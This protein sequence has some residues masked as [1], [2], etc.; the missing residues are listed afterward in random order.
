MR[1]Y[2]ENE[3]Y[4]N[5]ADI[6]VP[7]TNVSVE[8]PDNLQV[9]EYEDCWKIR[10]VGNNFC[11]PVMIEYQNEKQ[12][13]QEPYYVWIDVAGEYRELRYSYPGDIDTMLPDSEMCIPVE[14]I[15]RYTNEY[16]NQEE[17]VSLSDYELRIT[18]YDENGNPCYDR[19]LVNV[20]MNE[21]ENGRFLRLTSGGREGSTDI[22]IRAFAKDGEGQEYELCDNWIHV[23][24]S[25]SYWIMEP[26]CLEA[27]N[28]ERYNPGVGEILDLGSFDLYVDHYETGMGASRDEDVRIRLRDYDT[29]AWEVVSGTEGDLP[30]LKRT[31]N[32]G[33]EIVLIAE[34]NMAEEGLE[35]WKQVAER[36]Y[37]FD[38]LNYDIRFDDLRGGDYTW[39][40]ENEDIDLRMNTENLEGTDYTVEW[41]TGVWDENGNFTP[42]DP[43]LGFYEMS[44]DGTYITLHGAVLGT[45]REQMRDGCWFDVEA[46]IMMGG[47][48]MSR[49]GTGICVNE[50]E[51][52][53][54]TILEHPIDITEKV[55]SNALFE[56][57]AEG[58]DL[59]YQ[60]QYRASEAGT[61]A[62]TGLTGNKT[63][64]LIV[65]ALTT[66]NGFQYRCVITDKNGKTMESN[67]ATLTVIPGITLQPADITAAAGE[68]VVFKVAANGTGLTY[69]WQYRSSS[70][71]TWA[72][73]GL[74][75]NKTPSLTVG[76]LTGRNG[77]QYRCIITDSNKKTAI[78]NGAVLTVQTGPVITKQPSSVTKSVGST[79]VFSV[80][81]TGTALTYQW[82]WRASSSGTWA[83]SGFT[84]NKTANL[85]VGVIAAR[86]GYQ[87]RCEVIDSNGN[88][89]V[90]EAA[91]L[92]VQY[93]EK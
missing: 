7:I 20:E 23:N 82:Y 56:V 39:I 78:S 67:G 3:T 34:K 80:T 45:M 18:E 75:G 21:D 90:S 22:Q 28:G 76:A 37:W 36:H 4:P 1:E 84:G 74:S 70:S 47:R 27:G 43:G 29:D 86:N 92:T 65:G 62:N 69:Q 41:L 15:R 68:E 83:V 9:E 87:Y 71:G 19:E 72:N 40:Y 48:E 11:T 49:C 77:F 93:N 88:R 52:D 57:I 6:F 79:A 35:D 91:I 44:E 50:R 46:V 30:L 10:A 12:E 25:N 63:A 89:V 58:Y 13:N 51:Y 33:T 60:W 81:A 17:A 64:N 54:V 59:T 2:V 42:F 8:D 14:L 53:A 73:T 55:G 24:V 32:Q 85:T 38:W 5:G 61:W 16:G 66:R 26:S 31:G